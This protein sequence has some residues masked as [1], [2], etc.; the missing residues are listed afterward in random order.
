MGLFKQSRPRGFHHE[1]MFVDKRKD[2]LRDIEE[3]AQKSIGMEQKKK[4]CQAVKIV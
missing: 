1:F 3:R 4:I 2:V